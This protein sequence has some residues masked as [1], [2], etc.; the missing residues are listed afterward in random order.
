[1]QKTKIVDYFA[2]EAIIATNIIKREEMILR[3][4]LTQTLVLGGVYFIV[5]SLFAVFS[6]IIGT[7]F[8]LI[9]PLFVVIV[10]TIAF[11]RPIQK[12]IIFNNK[13]PN[14][15]LLLSVIGTYAYI[16][17][18]INLYGAVLESL[19]NDAGNHINSLLT[20]YNDWYDIIETVLSFSFVVGIIISCLIILYKN[21]KDKK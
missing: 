5:S 13:H 15:T 8:S 2:I 7:V 9:F 6:D 11:F 19:S 16:Y 18:A 3:K 4:A 14:I 20:S 1:M 21:I 10:V 12:I 17:F